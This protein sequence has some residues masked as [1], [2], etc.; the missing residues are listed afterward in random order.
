MRCGF[1]E[2]RFNQLPFSLKRAEFDD[3]VR[4]LDLTA[5]LHSF[6]RLVAIVRGFVSLIH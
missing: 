6:Y 5:I 2:I 1:Q 4:S 3:R